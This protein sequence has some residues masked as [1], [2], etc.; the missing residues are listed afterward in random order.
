MT[1]YCELKCIILCFADGFSE[2]KKGL[3]K[4]CREACDCALVILDKVSE[5]LTQGD[6]T[7]KELEKINES[8]KQMERLCD[9][10]QIEICKPKQGSKY[11]TVELRLTELK[12]FKENLEHLQN[13]CQ[14][15]TT[16]KVVGKP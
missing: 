14:S 2:A 15:L 6:I 12:V 3:P 1:Y 7:I 5:R 16:Y 9:A 10:A 8:L 13:V 11:T 4:T